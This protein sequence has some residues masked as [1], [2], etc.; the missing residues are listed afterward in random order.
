MDLALR[1]SSANRTPGDEVRGVLRC[2]GVEELAA[3]WEAHFRYVEEEPAGDA[4]ALVDLEA[5]VEVGVVDQT[6]P[7]DGCAW[8]F[9]VDAHDDVEVIFGGLC[10]F[11]E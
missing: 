6:F 4:E 2:D 11:A 5:V 10:V 3:G 7:A 9:E 1:R 8:F